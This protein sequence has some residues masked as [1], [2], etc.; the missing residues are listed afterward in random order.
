MPR[1]RNKRKARQAAK[2]AQRPKTSR[3][4]VALIGHPLQPAIKNTILAATLMRRLGRLA[5]E[6]PDKPRRCTDCN[7]RGA[8]CRPCGMKGLR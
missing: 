1:K 2:M 4:A 6:E 7:G 3:P 8:I 5:A